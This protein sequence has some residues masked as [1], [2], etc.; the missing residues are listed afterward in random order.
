MKSLMSDKGF[1]IWFTTVFFI[2]VLFVVPAEIAVEWFQ[3]FEIDIN[4]TMIRMITILSALFLA[5][6]AGSRYGAISM[7]TANES[8]TYKDTK[9][10][11]DDIKIDNIVLETLLVISWGFLII[12]ITTIIVVCVILY[13]MQVSV[14][15]GLKYLFS[16]DVILGFCIVTWYNFKM[17]RL[18]RGERDLTIRNSLLSMERKPL[19]MG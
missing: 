6:F 18:R 7:H 4:T 8:A 17:T 12:G 10:C 2:A 1:R 16:L 9:E 19:V 5:M 3:Y 13:L 15:D 11:Q 14:Y